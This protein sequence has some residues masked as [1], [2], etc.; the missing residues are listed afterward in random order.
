ME[1]VEN[2]KKNI[3]IV[4]P[5]IRESVYRQLLTKKQN[6]V[7][8][9]LI[10]TFKFS[11]FC[12]TQSDLSVLRNLI[13]TGGKVRVNP[14]LNANIYIFDDKKAVIS[15]ANLMEQNSELSHAYGMLV[16]DKIL[17]SEIVADYNIL[18]KEEKT[19]VVGKIEIEL[20]EKIIQQIYKLNGYKKTK[21]TK[22]EID[23]LRNTCDVAEVPVE[24]ISSV[25]QGWQQ[26][27]FNCINL[28]PYQI[29]TI[30]DLYLF[31]NHLKKLFPTQKN[32]QSKIAAPLNYFVELGLI[33]QFE[34]GIYKKL[35]RWVGS[36]VVQG[37]TYNFEKA[38][39]L[40][41]LCFTIK[42]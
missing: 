11:N 25:F 37:Q 19:R 16:D 3:K 15:S 2:T 27:V 29:F 7:K 36:M 1:L 6:K 17:V 13:E 23:I 42:S 9:E 22:N 8:I 28:T 39:T 32:I 31:E 5:F 4:T 41:Y 26:E 30:D 18:L 38:F 33:L 14:E 21:Y 12:S 35:W 34:N 10:T 24:A 20:L 40:F